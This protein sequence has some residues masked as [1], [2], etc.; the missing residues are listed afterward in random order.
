MAERKPRKQRPYKKEDV[1]YEYNVYYND[2]EFKKRLKRFEER[3]F[4]PPD[5]FLN[6]VYY[7]IE[8]DVAIHY[9][10]PEEALK[11]YNLALEFLPSTIGRY[12]G[13]AEY[14]KTHVGTPPN[15]PELKAAR[16]A[17]KRITKK[18]DR[19]VASLSGERKYLSGRGREKEKD[20]NGLGAK[21]AGIIA[22][23]FL[24][25]ALVFLSSNIT[26]N[27]IRNLSSAFSNSMGIVLFLIGIIGLIFYFRARK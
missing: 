2:P 12:E 5:G 19:L 11:Q 26:G 3:G 17:L 23:I 9:G 7:E 14:Y 8:G 22:I 1:D 10:E 24:L 6:E 4:I 18:R 16:L 27:V 13:E 21:V 25:G 20:S 15:D